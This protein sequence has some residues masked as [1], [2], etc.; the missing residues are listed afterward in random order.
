MLKIVSFWITD[1]FMGQHLT[2][3]PSGQPISHADCI[4]MLVAPVNVH[5][6]SAKA[7]SLEF[8]VFHGMERLPAKFPLAPCT[9]AV[10]GMINC[11]VLMRANDSPGAAWISEAEDAA[12]EAGDRP[13]AELRSANVSFAGQFIG[14]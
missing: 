7:P 2:V 12:A 11:E 10:G 3:R 13:T 9:S 14:R 1:P 8:K 4:D 5:H 6:E